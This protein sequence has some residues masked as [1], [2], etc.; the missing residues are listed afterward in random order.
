MIQLLAPNV[1]FACL[2]LSLLARFGGKQ[3]KQAKRDQ[4]DIN[5]TPP[6]FT[7]IVYYHSTD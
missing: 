7:T 1:R 2:C 3:A 4:L 6:S 5:S